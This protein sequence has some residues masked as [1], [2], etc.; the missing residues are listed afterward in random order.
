MSVSIPARGWYLEVEHP[1][2]NH[3]WTP[4]ILDVQRQPQANDYQRIRV[5]I[6]KNDHWQ[7]LVD[8]NASQSVP[9]RIWYNGTRQ[10]IDELEDV[11]DTEGETALIGRGGLKL[12]DRVTI[13]V[14]EKE[15]H[16]VA[17]D[18]I[19][20]QTSYS[21]NVDTPNTTTFATDN[22]VQS[23]DTN[24]EWKTV[25]PDIADDEPIT[26][27]NGNLE[28]LKST[29]FSEA[30]NASSGATTISGDYSSGEAQ[31]L[32][33]DGSFVEYNFNTDYLIPD[34]QYDIAAYAEL[35]SFEG[36]VDTIVNGTTVRDTTYSSPTD[37]ALSTSFGFN[38]VNQGDLDPGNG[39]QLRFEI[40]SHNNGSVYLDA[41][42]LVDSGDR[43]S[44]DFNLN[45]APSLDTNTNALDGPE[46]YPDK[47][48][49]EAV[50]VSAVGSIIEADLAVTMNDTSNK[51]AI[52]LSFDRGATWNETRNTSSVTETTSFSVNARAR[53][54]LSRFTNDS[55]TTPSS[56]DS[57]QTVDD[58][59]IKTDQEDMPILVDQRF[60][61]EAATVLQQ[62][63]EDGGFLW[64]YTVD[65]QGNGTVEWTQPGQRTA[66][67]APD[68][69]DFQSEKITSD[70][71]Q[72]A[73][74]KGSAQR[75]RDERF[76]SNHGTSVD[77]D[78]DELQIGKEIVYD[79]NDGTQFEYLRDYD[80]DFK[81][82]TIATQATG[83]MSDSTEYAID[84]SWIPV[85]TYT[86]QGVGTP[87]DETVEKIAVLAT[88]RGCD[89]VAFRIVDQVKTPLVEAVV[90]AP[91]ELG[92][93]VVEAVDISEL[94]VDDTLEVRGIENS[95]EET[96]FRLGTRERL[97]EFVTRIERRLSQL[98]G[99]I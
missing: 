76:T 37:G 12:S 41:L 53:V 58:L 55:S 72:K 20:N 30:E 21:A 95:P 18:I 9:F 96:V 67:E 36:T 1:N 8:N 66:S 29:Y 78:K 35:D 34:G 4:E 39:T 73:I 32:N 19:Q 88:E 33:A 84:Y 43:F 14:D 68:V 42:W 69:V 31:D 13:E 16:E 3:I 48:L 92:W 7:S 60:D 82:G 65:G 91:S 98:S 52:A 74:V 50:T 23:A 25:F 40:T 24:S 27:Q 85:G 38:G 49:V 11:E 10:P 57:G 87:S 83:T 80:M 97:D 77:L 56:G 26:V 89:Q 45:T 22:V 17:K 51:Q 99:R 90:T 79:P 59:K 71:N 46:T 93:S 70:V 61:D 28:L 94:P 63:A 47:Y 2:T 64:A 75:R 81:N 5:T 6:P 62:I 44:E 86:E 15:H 54:T